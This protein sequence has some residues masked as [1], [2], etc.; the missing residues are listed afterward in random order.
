MTYTTNMP[1]PTDTLAQSQPR[2]RVNFN[3]IDSYFGQD[4]FSFTAASNNGLHKKI[5][6]VGVNPAAAIPVT[7]EGITAIAEYMPNIAGAE[8]RQA[9]ALFYRQ[10]SAAH[11]DV[12]YQLTG[13]QVP[14]NAS[15]GCSSL[16]GGLMIQWGRTAVLPV[17][18][19]PDI[20][21]QI[22]FDSPP[23]SIVITAIKVGGGSGKGLFVKT[24]SETKHKFN[25]ENEASAGHDIY[26]IA[27][28]PRA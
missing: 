20:P 10:N 11:A 19:S 5:S 28:G 22:D 26:W 27:I 1:L 13:T 12:G 7:T 18:T 3:L 8:E 2:I 14:V 24:A 23:Y 17:G 6:F 9:Y 15:R 16:P 4:H 21:F 25:V